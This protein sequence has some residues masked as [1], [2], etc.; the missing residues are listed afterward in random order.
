MYTNYVLIVTL[1][2]SW[3]RS[4]LTE[5]ALQL[6]HFKVLWIEPSNKA[7]RVDCTV[8]L[9]VDDEEAAEEEPEVKEIPL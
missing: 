7:T 1:L 9:E 3:Y 6:L 4:T 5:V 2:M 8:T